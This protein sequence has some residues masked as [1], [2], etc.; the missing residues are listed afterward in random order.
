MRWDGLAAAV[1][2]VFAQYE[3]YL[4][5][6]QDVQLYRRRVKEYAEEVRIK[7]ERGETSIA[8]AD[9]TGIE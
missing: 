8:D 3:Q 7:L 6:A 2:E 5:S 9:S 4:P 1:A